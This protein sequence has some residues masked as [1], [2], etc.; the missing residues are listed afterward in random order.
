[1]SDKYSVARYKIS[2]DIRYNLDK[3]KWHNEQAAININILHDLN[4]EEEADKL[5]DE[6]KEKRK[7]QR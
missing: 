6:L 5:V 3:S 1:M 7:D 4:A 2:A